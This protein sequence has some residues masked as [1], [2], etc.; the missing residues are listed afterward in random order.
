[1][2]GA[3]PRRRGL[4]ERVLGEPI[5][6]L[7]GAQRRR[8]ELAR[9]LFAIG[10]YPGAIV[11]VTHDPSAIDALRPDRVL[12]LPDADEDLWS[13]TYLDLITLT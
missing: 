8:V 5:G 7:S 11:M 4:P 10:T 12:P 3:V 2:A 13:D 1:M 6:A 9:I